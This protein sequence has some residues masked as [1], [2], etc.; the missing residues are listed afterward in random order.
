MNTDNEEC[1]CFNNEEVAFLLMALER[2]HY[3][4]SE[5]NQEIARQIRKILG[6]SI[7]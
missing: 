1:N 6:E 3:G 5:D 2:C 4:L 7:I